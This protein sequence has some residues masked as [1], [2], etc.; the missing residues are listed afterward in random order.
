MAAAAPVL[1]GI[2]DCG[3]ERARRRSSCITSSSTWSLVKACTV[4]MRPVTRPIDSCSGFTSGARQLVV[5]E[6]FEMTVCAALRF[7][8]FTP[9]TTVA[10]TSLPPGAEMI[11]FLAPPRR[12]AAAVG[13]GG[14]ADSHCRE[15]RE[16]AREKTTILAD[17]AG[18]TLIGWCRGGS[19]RP[20]GGVVRIAATDCSI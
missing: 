17:R 6:A 19:S 14:D 12:G 18:A 8:W 1:D 7:A 16:K 20:G 2:I 5:H 10:S 3:A 15:L 13:L 11:T 4:V 9:Y